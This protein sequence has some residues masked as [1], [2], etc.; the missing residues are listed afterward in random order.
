MTHDA[1]WVSDI[2]NNNDNDPN[3][4]LV[5]EEYESHNEELRDD[6]DQVGAVEEF[7]TVN[8]DDDEGSAA[9][10]SQDNFDDA[11]GESVDWGH[12]VESPEQEV[13]NKICFE[14]TFKIWR[15]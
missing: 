1:P 11:W 9:W 12:N 8:T 14:Q 5:Q 10:G 7:E 3:E 6:D 15:A 13:M 4:H 2:A